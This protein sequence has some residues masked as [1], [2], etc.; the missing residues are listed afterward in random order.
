MSMRVS[1][2]IAE[3]IKVKARA[4]Q[5]RGPFLTAKRGSTHNATKARRS[6]PINKWEAKLATADDNSFP[7]GTM[8]MVGV[9]TVLAEVLED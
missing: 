6:G 2:T 8:K 5:C 3:C 4:Q 7:Q 1:Y 9:E